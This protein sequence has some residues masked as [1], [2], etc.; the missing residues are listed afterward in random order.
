MSDYLPTQ[1][2]TF[3]PIGNGDSTTVSINDDV[4]LQIDLHHMVAAEDEDEEYFPVV[5]HLVEELP[6]IDGKPYLSVFALT[7]PDKDHIQGFDKLLDEAT[8]GELWLTPRI[9]DD[10]ELSKEADAFYEEADRRRKLAIEK[11][12]DLE[13]G[14]KIRIF[15]YSSILEED[16]F[17]GFPED[18]LT[19]PGESLSLLD[20]EDLGA[21]FH[22]FIHSPFKAEEDDERNDTSLGMQI[23][24]GDENDDLKV[25]IFG[26]LK[27][28]SLRKIIDISKTNENEDKLEWNILLAPHH[29]SKSVMYTKDEN[30][31]NIFQREMMD[32]L[33]S[34]CLDIGYVVSSSKSIPA[35]NKKGDNPP[36]AIA[37][38]RYE[39]IVS[40]DFLCTHNDESEDAEPIVFEK[41][42]NA[43]VLN[44]EAVSVNAVK[45]LSD[46]VN[47]ARAS[48]TPPTNTAGFGEL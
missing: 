20:G 42:D 18:L 19:L 47:D 26:D 22:A 39:E 14:D 33:E 15:G 37:K 17:K 9:F 34:Y 21:E 36:H 11:N 3:W 13:S 44:G 10:E 46:S 45:S 7:H 2:V 25:L 32:D 12:G 5:D 27:H 43:L 48:G 8:I 38:E 31:K 35:S 16:K 28:D 41:T 6:E 29:C 40:T 4:K 24:L 1:G 30:D 23:S